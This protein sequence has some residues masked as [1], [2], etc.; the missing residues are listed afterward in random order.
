[1]KTIL[2]LLSISGCA[3]L[4]L[5]SPMSLP[6][7]Q[8]TNVVPQPSK[9][10]P[11]DAWQRRIK[12]IHFDGLPLGEVAKILQEQEF[13]PEV[14]FV[15]EPELNDLPISVSQLRSVGLEDIFNA[16][17]IVTKGK[18]EIN[19]LVDGMVT[20]TRTKLPAGEAKAVCQAF[21]L[22]SYL[23]M[24]TPEQSAKALKEL[25]SAFDLCWNMLE[26]ANPNDPTG[27]PQF[28]IHSGTRLLIA[29][30]SPEQ[31]LVIEQVI[32]QL[33]DAKTRFTDSLVPPA[34]TSTNKPASA[35]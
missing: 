28:N 21:S 8:Q 23:A 11:S 26:R 3:L 9:N 34:S 1:M 7:Q 16:I 33:G 30:G 29:V 15:T 13:F 20:F 27:R 4:L 17:K 25:E 22:N 19:R 18:V 12:E 35:K 5:A 32:G 24:R 2:N 14:N 10:R 31:M 6:A